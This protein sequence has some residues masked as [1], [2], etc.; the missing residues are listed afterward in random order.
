MGWVVSS[1]P[2][3]VP[4]TSRGHRE[5]PRGHLRGWETTGHPTGR[6]RAS[7]RSRGLLWHP[8][9]PLGSVRGSPAHPPSGSRPF[10]STVA[11][12]PLGDGRLPACPRQQF[13]RHRASQ[14]PR[15]GHGVR[16][17]DLIQPDQPQ[18]QRH[19]HR[20]RP[21]MHTQMPER[22]HQQRRRPRPLNAQHPPGRRHRVTVRHQPQDLK[23]P[24][25]QG[26]GRCRGAHASPPAVGLGPLSTNDSSGW[27]EFATSSSQSPWHGS[28]IRHQHMSVFPASCSRIWSRYPT[29]WV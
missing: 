18:P 8:R 14:S 20:M 1:G 27:G 7:G 9:A 29:S 25:G 22:L 28:P 13:G 6:T 21:V 5:S 10:G 2:R 4:C 24:A 17:P 3:W 23:L 15:R 16:Q 19:R 26:P 11:C 12:A